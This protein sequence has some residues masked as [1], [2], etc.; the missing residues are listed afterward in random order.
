MLRERGDYF[1][2]GCDDFIVVT[3]VIQH[4][5]PSAG[6]ADADHFADYLAV[7][8]NSGDDVGRDDC[9]ETVVPELHHGSI[10]P[11][12]FHVVHPVFCRSL[13]RFVQHAFRKIDTDNLAMAGVHRQS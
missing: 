5:D 2:D 7:V 13:L 10:H 4:D 12:Q 11:V 9:V 8:G 3:E 6:S 1:L